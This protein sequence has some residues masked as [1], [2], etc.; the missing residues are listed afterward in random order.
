[1]LNP[2]Q[3][4]VSGEPGHGKDKTSSLFNPWCVGAAPLEGSESPG[5]H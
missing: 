4:A 2:Q 1:M 3:T 5:L